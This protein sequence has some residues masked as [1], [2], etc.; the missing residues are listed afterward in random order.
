[1]L[2]YFT[3]ILVFL[4]G[5]VVVMEASICSSICSQEDNVNLYF[6]KLVEDCPS[7][8]LL[9]AYQVKYFMYNYEFFFFFCIWVYTNLPM[10]IHMYAE[11][12]WK[13]KF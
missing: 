5:A 3:N 7:N 2:L 13:T 1:M 8:I 4:T 12:P 11:I 6:V 10:C 9:C